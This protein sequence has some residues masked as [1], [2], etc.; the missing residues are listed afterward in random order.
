MIEPRQQR[1]VHLAV[2]DDAADRSA[3]KTDAVIAALAA[4]Q[5]GAAALALDLV[6]GQRDFERGIGGLR[7]GIA[8]EN[9]IEAFWGEVRDAACQ[10][11]RLPESEF[12]KR[13]LNHRPRPLAH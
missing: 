4:D 10:L 2:I 1:A 5:A 11:K 13:R 9:V 6:I 3:A 12:K 7:T 8:E